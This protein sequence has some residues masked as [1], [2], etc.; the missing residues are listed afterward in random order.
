MRLNVMPGVFRPISGSRLLAD[1]LR[2]ELWPGAHVADVCTGSGV[3]AVTAALHGDLLA[4]L[5]ERQFDLIVSNP[6]MYPP[7]R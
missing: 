3:L 6:P 7:G 5:A 2:R 1:C 4:P